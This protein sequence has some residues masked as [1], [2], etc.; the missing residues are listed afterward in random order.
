MILGLSDG[1]FPSLQNS[2]SKKEDG[3]KTLN[4]ARFIAA[5]FGWIFWICALLGWIEWQDAL[6]FIRMIF[7]L[8]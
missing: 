5:F 3:T 1:I 2:I 4:F 8:G 6:S 7:L